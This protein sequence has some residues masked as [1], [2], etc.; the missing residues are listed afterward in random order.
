MIPQRGQNGNGTAVADKVP[1]AAA[2]VP[3]VPTPAGQTGR[4]L[5]WRRGRGNEPGNN[6]NRTSL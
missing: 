6:F 4:R 3:D 5:T 1:E 2:N